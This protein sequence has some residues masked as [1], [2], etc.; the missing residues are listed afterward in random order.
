MIHENG[1]AREHRRPNHD[2]ADGE[3]GDHGEDGK[4]GQEPGD[5]GGN[6][7]SGIQGHDGKDG[8]NAHQDFNV[9]IDYKGY[10]EKTNSR[11]YLVTTFV[12][13]GKKT[14]VIPNCILNPSFNSDR[15]RQ[16]G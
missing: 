6:G 1:A 11:T 16:D 13:G 14:E 15:Y 9:L 3:D 5:N 4:D 7:R 10:D 12:E 8:H 2:G